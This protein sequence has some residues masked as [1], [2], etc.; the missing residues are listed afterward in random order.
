MPEAERFI[1]DKMD[2][3]REPTDWSEPPLLPVHGVPRS[4]LQFPPATP[5]GVLHFYFTQVSSLTI[6]HR[7][8]KNTSDMCTKNSRFARSSPHSPQKRKTVRAHMRH[9]RAECSTQEPSLDCTRSHSLGGTSRCARPRGAAA[10]RPCCAVP[11]WSVASASGCR[12]G[13][14]GAARA[15]QRCVSGRATQ[16]GKHSRDM[17]GE[18]QR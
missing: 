4:Q 17:G 10:A 6:L 1:Q 12:G 15:Q 2:T 3:K 9:L 5:R 16:G 14:D 18:S 7:T 8:S 13:G 11:R